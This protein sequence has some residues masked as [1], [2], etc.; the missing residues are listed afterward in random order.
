MTKRLVLILIFLF[1]AASILGGLFWLGRKENKKGI[2]PAPE[3]VQPPTEE[4]S[5]PPL[6]GSGEEKPPP[7]PVSM[8]RLK[9]A[10]CVTDGLLSQY[11]P[12]S[13]QFIGLVNRSNCYYLHRAIET[14]R[15]PPRFEVV[16]NVM[17]RIAKKDVVYDMFIAEALDTNDNYQNAE[18]GHY[19]R[20]RKMCHQNSLNHWGEHTCV[21]TFSSSEYRDYL[22][23]ITRRA[24]DLGVQSF[25][26][27][28]IYMQESSSRKYAPQIVKKIRAYAEK[29]GVDVVIGA[30]TDSITDQKYL[31]LFDFIEGGVGIDSNGDVENGPCLSTR[32]SC[33]AL[34]WNKAYSAKAKNVLLHLD[35]TGIPSD[36]LDI[37]ARMSP[38]KRAETLQKLYRK[39]TSQNMGFLM[40]YFGVLDKNNG[41]CFGPKKRYYSPDNAYGC[42]DEDAINA[43]LGGK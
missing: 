40:P 25:T 8:A 10:G 15:N 7:P 19:F 38:E 27:G 33:W 37:F 6:P 43:I 5:V 21:P 3:K 30:Q 23:Y 1:L 39:F 4:I 2:K 14:W 31:K 24:I 20:F 42:R 41:G 36:D 9:K 32:G 35:W 13:D 11:N 29:K 22:R 18:S 26:F 16:N 12:D 28:Q 34:L 17:N